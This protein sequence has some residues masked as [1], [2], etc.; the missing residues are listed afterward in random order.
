MV[1]MVPQDVCL[2]HPCLLMKGL[3]LGGNLKLKWKK[4]G[5]EFPVL[6]ATVKHHSASC[7]IATVSSLH[8]GWEQS[9]PFA[10]LSYPRPVWPLGLLFTLSQL[11][12]DLCGYP[13]QNQPYSP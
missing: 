6:G 11:L 9:V 2:L 8:Q 3:L 10:F 13:V 7:F 5:V 1:L 12:R 4:E